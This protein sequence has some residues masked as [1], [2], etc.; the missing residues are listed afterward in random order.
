MILF[1]KNCG[2]KQKYFL[3]IICQKVYLM[4]NLIFIYY[5]VINV[6]EKML[7]I[8]KICISLKMTDI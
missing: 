5:V 1:I 6:V 7:S 3:Q 4:F 8:D 2:W